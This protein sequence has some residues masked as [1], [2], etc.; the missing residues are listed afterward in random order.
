[1]QG[2]VGV[3]NRIFKSLKQGFYGADVEFFWGGL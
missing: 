2:F 1:M 3:L